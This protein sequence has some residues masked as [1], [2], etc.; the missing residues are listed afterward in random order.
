MKRD[1]L[2]VTD[3]SIDEV[4]A[5]LALA[6]SL[7]R[8]RGTSAQ[9][10]LLG[11]T[12]AML[13]QYPSLR[14]KASFDVAA[15]ELGAHALYLGDDEVKMGERESPADVARVLSR[16]VQGVVARL[17]SHAEL[18]AFAAAATVPV[19]NALTDQEHPCQALAD[20]LTLQERRG[21]LDGA[22]FVYVGDADNNVATSLLLLAP[23]LGVRVTVLCPSAYA[24]TA[25]VLERARQ[26]GG[27]GIR[28]E[29]DLRRAEI[30]DA[31]A[32]Y[33]DVWVSMGQDHEAEER[34]AALHPYQ[35]NAS[36]LERAGP[37]CIVLH[38]LPAKRGQ[39]ITD[40]VIDGPR[41]AVF[42]QAENRLHAQKALLRWLLSPE[43][44]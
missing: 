35:V 28:V 4:A 2:S 43:H 42:D 13:F 32:I 29:Y 33:T 19:V 41:S 40:D 6:G 31:D 15:H 18:Q 17:K 26:L 23:R 30:A 27:A 25:S 37:R 12:V 3:L 11:Q 9:R 20:L 16:Y 44:G 36:L 14:T 8:Q 1:V 24:P 7:K 34:K 38:C 5:L 10:P 21:C 39:E 22:H